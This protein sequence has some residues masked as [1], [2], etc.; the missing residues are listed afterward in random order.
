M[1]FFPS[2]G[3]ALEDETVV[4][5]AVAQ[6]G[7]AFKLAPATWRLLFKGLLRGY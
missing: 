6:D 3:N 2:K 1:D 7:E 4:L 5:A